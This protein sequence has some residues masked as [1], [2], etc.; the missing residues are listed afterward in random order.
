MVIVATV[1]RGFYE[2]LAFLCF[3]AE[4]LCASLAYHLFLAFVIPLCTIYRIPHK[5][6]KFWMKRWSIIL[7]GPFFCFFVVLCAYS[8][9]NQETFNWVQAAH[10]LFIL[11]GNIVFVT[12]L[13]VHSRNLSRVLASLSRSQ[14]PS[15][16]LREVQT[17][18]MRTNLMTLA[19]IVY[20]ILVVVSVGALVTMVL[21]LG[22]AMF[23]WIFAMI[24][25]HF[26]LVLG[27]GIAVFLKQRRDAGD[28]SSLGIIVD[29]GPQESDVP[30][31]D[32]MSWTKTNTNTKHLTSPSFRRNGHDSG[33]IKGMLSGL[34]EESMGPI[35]EITDDGDSP[36]K[37]RVRSKRAQAYPS[38]P[39]ISESDR[40]AKRERGV[41]V[42]SSQAPSMVQS[43][44]PES[45]VKSFHDSEVAPRSRAQV[46][47]GRNY[48]T[49]SSKRGEVV[50]SVFHSEAE[51]T[52]GDRTR[53]AQRKKRGM[54]DIRSKI[55]STAEGGGEDPD[56]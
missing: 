30:G 21:V 42:Q 49:L 1:E 31:D 15:R 55:M 27:T 24:I 10:C 7:S 34:G 44:I 13:I 25:V 40:V 19:L 48:S 9:G 32:Y 35:T 28:R 47:S 38:A 11:A 41:V 52:I 18:E 33:V 6:I 26:S 2:G 3:V 45:S 8:R 12:A 4:A 51:T 46:I 16:R 53:S 54:L 23:G 20:L 56:F 17:L 14:M 29:R 37:E 43:S 22:S 5:K 36:E 39:Q 50:S